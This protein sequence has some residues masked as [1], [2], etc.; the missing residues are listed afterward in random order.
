[1]FVKETPGFNFESYFPTR[2]E[3]TLRT[4]SKQVVRSFFV[5]DGEL[6]RFNVL[7]EYLHE[8]VSVGAD[9]LVVE[10]QSVE[11]FVLYDVG[12]QAAVGLQGHGLSLSLAAQVG[13]TP[14]TQKT[15]KDLVP[16]GGVKGDNDNMTSY[17]VF[18]RTPPES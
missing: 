11:N 5:S 15:H 6:T 1:M 3:M 2:E 17:P 13:P 16:S 8:V 18:L 7:V 12:V 10:S 9:L 14:G 4:F